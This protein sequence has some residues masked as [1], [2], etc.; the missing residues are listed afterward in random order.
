MEVNHL[1]KTTHLSN[2]LMFTWKE[3]RDLAKWLI[4]LE[5]GQKSCVKKQFS[6]TPNFC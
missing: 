2:R 6:L 5:A 3:S 1:A 4:L